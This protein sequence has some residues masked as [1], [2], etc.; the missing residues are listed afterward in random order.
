[1][2]LFQAIGYC[3]IPQKAYWDLE[4]YFLDEV[5]E[6]LEIDGTFIDTHIYVNK[7]LLVVL[8]SGIF[9]QTIRDYYV[10]KEPLMFKFI[11]KTLCAIKDG[12]VVKQIIL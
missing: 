8:E 3:D 9:S 1:M 7:H 2:K 5:K 6:I 11:N 4:N 10:S 12:K